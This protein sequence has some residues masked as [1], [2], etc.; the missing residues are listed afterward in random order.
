ME[1][2]NRRLDGIICDAEKCAY[3]KNRECYASHIKVEPGSATK[4]NQTECS[5]F[6]CKSSCC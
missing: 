5:T 4:A 1:N 3:N 2:S 6:K